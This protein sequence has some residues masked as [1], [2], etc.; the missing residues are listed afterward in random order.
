MFNIQLHLRRAVS[1]DSVY[2]LALLLS[3]LLHVGAVI[4]WLAQ[5]MAMPAAAVVPT[6]VTVDLIAAPSAV[7]V[8]QAQPVAQSEVQPDESRIEP[9]SRDDEMAVHRKVS[10]KKSQKKIATQKPLEHKQ[11][12]HKQQEQKP[13]TQTQQSSI[14]QL[15]AAASEVKAQPVQSGSTVS[16]VTAARFEA[17]YVSH[18]ATYPPLSR[19]LG[20]QG[21]VV[22]RVLVSVEGKP[23]QIA[24]KKSSG[25][26][27][28][29]EAALKAVAKWQ[30]SPAR[31][32]NRAVASE[33]EVPILFQFK[34]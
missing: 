1:A 18:P 32:G 21:R 27:R 5:P 34:K 29:D 30:F 7:A 22:L 12:E 31:Q 6:T 23:T 33:V 14:V 3:V 8:P 28:L 9:E 25:F 26:A 2:L 17:N 13:T 24:L 15:N 19:R 11:Q 16:S 10:K 20:E 4:E